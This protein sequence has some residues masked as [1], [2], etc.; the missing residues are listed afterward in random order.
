MSAEIDAL[1]SFTQKL[2][3]TRSM[4]GEEQGAVK[5]ISSEMEKLKYDR[6]WVDELG[7]LIGVIEGSQPGPTILLDGHCDTV[8]ANS[9]DWT[10]SPWGGELS[11]GRLYG[12]GTVDM[13]GSLAA[14]VHAAGGLAR[15][16]LKGKIAV[17]AT[18]C[19]EFVEG[20]ALRNVVDKINPD[21]VVIGEATEFNLNR[22]GRGRAEL[23]LSTFGKSAHSSSPSAGHCAI[24]DMV[25]ALQVISNHKMPEDPVL[26]SG[27][28]VLTDIISEP[29]PGHSVIP[30]RCHVTFDRRLLP[31]ETEA[32]IIEDIKTLP[33]LKDIQFDLRLAMQDER[34]YTGVLLEGEKFYPAWIF[35]EAHPFVQAAFRGLKSTGLNPGIGTYHFCTNA[36]YSAGV[37]GIPSV[38][39]GI[40]REEEAHIVDESISLDDLHTA[41]KGYQGIIRA[42]C[43]CLGKPRPARVLCERPA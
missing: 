3:Q 32:S 34:T 20:G 8:D 5:L 10:H 28:L 39:F 13:K 33:G 17:S 24:T 38:G 31:G 7:N 16:N 23:K 12:R 37:K 6:V 29:Y 14:M 43:S 18:V 26:G 15:D 19:E 41:V 1:T 30:Y 40:G 21:Y 2:V 9:S 35:P 11:D 22:G 36:A 27:S 4:T 42:V 25:H